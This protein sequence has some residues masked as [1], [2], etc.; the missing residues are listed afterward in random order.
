MANVKPLHLS[1]QIEE[2]LTKE[3]MGSPANRDTPFYNLQKMY[4]YDIDHNSGFYKGWKEKFRESVSEKLA[5]WTL[6]NILGGIIGGIIVV[7]FFAL[8]KIKL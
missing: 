3:W 5:E 8:F 7:I 6:G 4:K 2:I 1:Q